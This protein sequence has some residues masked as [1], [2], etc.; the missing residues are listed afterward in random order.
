MSAI[1]SGVQ[2][3]TVL[4]SFALLKPKFFLLFAVS[5]TDQVLFALRAFSV[6]YTASSSD[7]TAGLY[8]GWLLGTQ[9]Y[10]LH[11]V[12]AI[13]TA[14]FYTAYVLIGIFYVIFQAPA[15]I[16]LAMQFVNIQN[17]QFFNQWQVVGDFGWP[18]LLFVGEMLMGLLIFINGNTRQ[19]V[20]VA[21][22][23]L[24]D[25][26]SALMI[27]SPL[28]LKPG[29]DL[30]SFGR[31]I[32]HLNDLLFTMCLATPEPE[33]EILVF[34]KS[35]KPVL[36]IPDIPSLSLEDAMSRLSHTEEQLKKLLD[37]ETKRKA[38]HSAIE[39]RRNEKFNGRIQQL[40]SLVGLSSNVTQVQVLE[41]VCDTIVELKQEVNQLRNK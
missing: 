33:P 25:W 30:A 2:A 1:L 8:I 35:E 29:V 9:L 20:C 23:M 7:A 22:M 31:T 4:T 17:F 6:K 27:L 37:E 12:G 40:R 16:Q 10:H 28:I 19:R 14:T 32:V 38:K 13:K 21:L 18:G 3:V 36:P 39:K 34:E 11:N 24:I 26:A 15:W 5:L 41:R